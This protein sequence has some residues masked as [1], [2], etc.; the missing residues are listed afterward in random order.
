VFAALK[1]TG[2]EAKTVPDAAKDTCILYLC[3]IAPAKILRKFFRYMTD[4]KI[5]Q[6][7]YKDKGSKRQ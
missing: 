6:V 1:T 5:K 3:C 7:K 2:S 4:K